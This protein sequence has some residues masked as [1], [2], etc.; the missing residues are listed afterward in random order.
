MGAEPSGPEHR[1]YSLFLYCGSWFRA[2]TRHTADSAFARRY[3]LL[4]LLVLLVTGGFHEHACYPVPVS[5]RWA[6]TTPV[7]DNMA[8]CLQ[9]SRKRFV[10]AKSFV[11]CLLPF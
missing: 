10:Q 6:L 4:K 5:A 11:Q 8:Q 9:V 2:V 7:Q 3:V 1:D